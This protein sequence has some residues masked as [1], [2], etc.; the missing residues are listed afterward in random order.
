MVADRV[1]IA[2]HPFPHPGRPVWGPMGGRVWAGAVWA[3]GSLDLGRLGIVLA[4]GR[5]KKPVRFLLEKVA[6]FCPSL[7]RTLGE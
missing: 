6:R 4:V 2:E 5:G 7:N 3:F 1:F